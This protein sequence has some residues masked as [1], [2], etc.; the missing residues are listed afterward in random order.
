MKKIISGM[1]LFSC[2]LSAV[3]IEYEI[4]N[5]NYEE[6]TIFKNKLSNIYIVEIDGV[7]RELLS[8]ASFGIRCIKKMQIHVN[9]YNIGG[10]NYYG[11][12]FECGK[13]IILKEK[14]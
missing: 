13:I 14:R 10:S 7:K 12:S 11:R 8:Q 6:Q 2:I 1:I 4:S 3:E 5:N 9:T